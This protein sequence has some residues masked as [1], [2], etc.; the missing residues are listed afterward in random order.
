MRSISWKLM[1]AFVVISLAG[2]GIFF[3]IARYN[4]S[5]EI[6]DLLIDQDQSIILEEL[7]DYY[8]ENGS[9]DGLGDGWREGQSGEGPSGRPEFFSPFMVVNLDKEMV[10]GRRGGPGEYKKGDLIPDEELQSAQEITLDG[11]IIGWLVFQ[12]PGPDVAKEHPIFQ[13]LD[14]LLLYSALGS[15]LLALVLG[16]LF[17]RSLSRPLQELSAAAR[18]AATGD[19]SHKVEV[20]AKDEIGELAES[21][22]RMMDDLERL[23]A[24]RKQMTADIAHELR[25]PISIILGHADGVSD[26][27][28]EPS[29]ENFEI[30]RD[31]AL[32]LERLVSDLRTL[33][34]A[35]VG[36]LPLEIVPFEVQSFL[37]EVVKAA[38]TG[39]REKRIGLN[40]DAEPDLPAVKADQDRILQVV[41]NILDNAIRYT[42]EGGQIEVRAYMV[43]EGRVCFSI[44]DNGPGL[45]PDELSRIFNRFYQVDSARTRDKNGSGLGL[46]IAKS[47]VEQH[48]GEIWADS[49]PGEGLRISF[50]LPGSDKS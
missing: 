1:L 4:S 42:P 32:H 20:N 37:S 10:S 40:V 31:E 48:G 15:I 9:W 43:D 35:D 38:S 36:E 33:S 13:R 24:N 14:T 50:T 28:L 41:R 46:A 19:L 18:R 44:Q 45:E 2:T 26:G 3:V 12:P 21:F 11:E 23:M 27:V 30:I 8:A 7:A 6:Q 5:R 25:T 34:Q 29:Q 39:L 22:N 47:I 16:L 49:S 17:S